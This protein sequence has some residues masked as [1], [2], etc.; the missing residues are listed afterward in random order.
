MTTLSRQGRRKVPL[1]IVSLVLSIGFSACTHGE[2]EDQ[3][4]TSR[5]PASSEFYQTDRGW[6]SIKSALW[7]PNSDSETVTKYLDKYETTIKQIRAII[8]SDR[9]SEKAKGNAILNWMRKQKIRQDVIN[10]AASMPASLVSYVNSTTIK[11]ENTARAAAFLGAK[12]LNK[13]AKEKLEEI[14]DDAS[15]ALSRISLLRVTGI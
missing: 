8:A 10:H 7:G 3:A 1:V 9:Y 14:D 2:T 15:S 12:G 11:A 4:K 6:Y 5:N 13:A